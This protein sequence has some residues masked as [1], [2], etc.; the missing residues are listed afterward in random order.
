MQPFVTLL[1]SFT[2][3]FLRFLHVMGSVS[4]SLVYLITR[5]DHN[6]LIHSV[7]DDTFVV[8]TSGCYEQCSWE[9]S[10]A[11][12]CVDGG[13]HSLGLGARN[14]TAG[15]HGNSMFN[16]F[17]NYQ[18]ASQSGCTILQFFLQNQ[19]C[20]RVSISP[21]P[22]QH[23]LL[24]CFDSTDIREGMK[25]Y[26]IVVFICNSLD[27]ILKSRDITLPTKVHLV[28]ALVF[29]VRKTRCESWTINKAEHLEL[30]LLNCGVGED[31]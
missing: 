11:S 10:G 4:P 19:Y 14:G 23:L 20:M 22:C 26:L 8:P 28:K 6:L 27:S 30:M 2:I 1:L 18:A 24:Y 9:H 21:C 3:M 16:I 29:P 25:C 13:F 7:F 5:R 15:S 12:C 17:R 31:S